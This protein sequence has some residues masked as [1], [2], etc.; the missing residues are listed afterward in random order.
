MFSNQVAEK[1]FLEMRRLANKYPNIKFIA[2]SHGSPK[3]TER[4]LGQ[5]GG[6]WSVNIIT[7]EERE[8]YAVWGLGISTGYYLLNPWTQMASR[9]LG[10]EEG[11]WAREV[12]EG[13]N[14]WVIGGAWGIDSSKCLFSLVIRVSENNSLGKDQHSECHSETA[15]L[16]LIFWWLASKVGCFRSR[17]LV[18][19]SSAIFGKDFPFAASALLAFSIAME[20]DVLKRIMIAN[21]SQWEQSSVVVQAKLQTIFRT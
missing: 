5:I 3:T 17:R 2:V 12:G 11:I 6:A 18:S 19:C 10:N 14:R 16:V 15:S 7:D 4:W 9:K 21:S 20:D 8:V 13:G 1:T